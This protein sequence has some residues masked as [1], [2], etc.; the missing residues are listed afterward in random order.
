ML[1]AFSQ[2]EIEKVPYCNNAPFGR[3]TP[4]LSLPA[5]KASP[6]GYTE[7]EGQCCANTQDALSLSKNIG[8][9]IHRHSPDLKCPLAAWR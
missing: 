3:G 1:T 9:T 6:S 2:A 4:L 8:N 7:G 5:D